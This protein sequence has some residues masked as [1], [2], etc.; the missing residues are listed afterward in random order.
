MLSLAEKG[1]SEP[2]ESV[3][4]G[5][6]ILGTPLERG[7]GPSWAEGIVGEF[8]RTG[9]PILLAGEK[10]RDYRNITKCMCREVVAGRGGLEGGVY[11]DWSSSST[12][13]RIDSIV[14]RCMGKRGQLKSG[15]DNITRKEVELVFWCEL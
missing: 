2:G 10:D 12:Y 8:S 11:R 5:I 7:A 13:I 3:P 9:M 14:E 6:S 4:A 15:R 1:A